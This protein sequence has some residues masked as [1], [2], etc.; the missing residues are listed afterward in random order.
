MPAQIDT[1]ELSAALKAAGLKASG[2]GVARAM[3][4][5]A[6][7]DVPSQ[8]ELREAVHLMSVRMGI[9]IGASTL[10]LMIAII[11]ALISL[12]N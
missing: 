1:L 8:S 11:G 5:I 3:Q 6:M 10:A 4:D 12:A 9:M 7:R 2:D